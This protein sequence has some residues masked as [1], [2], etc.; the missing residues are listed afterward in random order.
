MG[1]TALKAGAAKIDITPPLG[2]LINGDFINHYAQRVYDPLYV[3]A[4]VFEDSD[5]AL[6][7]V[8]V[9]T[10]A[11]RRE[12]LDEV[13]KEIFLHAGLSPE[14]VLISSTHTH[15]GGALASLLL[16]AADIEYRKT[17]SAAI[18]ETILTAQQSLRPAKIAFGSASAPEHLLCRRYKMDDGYI[19][20]NPVTGSTDQVKTNPFGAE[21][22]ILQSAAPVD[23]EIGYMAVQEM[24]GTWISLLANYSLH[25][26]GDW[27]KGTICGD[28]FGAFSRA[29]EHRLNIGNDFLAVMTNGTS[30]DVNIWDFQNPGRYP[31]GHHQ[32]SESIG[33]ALAE[34][35]YQSLHG[36]AWEEGATIAT[37]Y[38]EMTLPVR[39]ASETELQTAKSMLEKASYE[40]MEMN[41]PERLKEVYAR[42]QL[43]LD[44]YPD[45]INFPVQAIRIGKGIIG[46]LGGEFFSETGLWLKEQINGPY[47]T[48]TMANDY[49]GYVPPE[50]EI[51]K[52]GYET[53]R[54]RTSYLGLS[55]EETIRKQLLNLTALL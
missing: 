37:V 2:T 9:D 8:V 4:L 5:S 23:P 32:K 14:R 35:V 26:V 29:I 22:K 31:D 1:M 19:A 36:L 13:K 40:W 12:F 17:V 44:A 7:I 11:M 50:H 34:R 38:Q 10:C 54:C 52:G 49:V 55:S 47:F 53:W 21:A 30:G 15:A 18:V 24:D 25:Y 46:A 41:S 3:K 45:H 48:V 16:G 33:E 43:L 39:K 51:E 20:P 42:E 28:Y 27:E 6:A